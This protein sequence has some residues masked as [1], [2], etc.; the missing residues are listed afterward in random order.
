ME[1]IIE[2]NINIHARQNRHYPSP[3]HKMGGKKKKKKKEKLEMILTLIHTLALAVL[4]DW[5]AVGRGR[6]SGRT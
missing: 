4:E 6:T 2:K 1:V 3:Y 5:G